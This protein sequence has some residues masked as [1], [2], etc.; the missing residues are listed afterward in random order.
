M[1]SRM[2][3]SNLLFDLI[4]C[5]F[6]SHDDEIN[7]N[8]ERIVTDLLRTIFR[9]H[10]TAGGFHEFWPRFF[11][12]PIKFNTM[13]HSRDKNEDSVIETSEKMKSVLWK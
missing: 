12:I 10:L 6:F 5:L 4:V 9:I 3:P 7:K 1:T 2:F 13:M 11:K 8:K